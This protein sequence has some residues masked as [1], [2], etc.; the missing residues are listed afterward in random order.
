MKKAA[1]VLATS[2]AFFFG[3]MNA[4]AGRKYVTIP[5][6]KSVAT[7]AGTAVKDTGRVHIPGEP[8]TEYIPRTGTGTPGTPVK[9]LPTLDYSIPRTIN[10]AKNILKGNLGQILLQGTIAAAVAGVG[11]VMSDDNTKIQRKGNTVDGI[12]TSGPNNTVTWETTYICGYM[13]ASSILGKITPITYKN[14]LYAVWVGPSNAIPS[15]YTLNGNNCTQAGFPPGTVS[16]SR[17]IAFTDIKDGKFD[18]S[19][20]DW[21]GLDT[22][23]NAQGADWIK[24]LIRESCGGTYG[25]LNPDACYQGL[26]DSSKLSGP[27]TVSGGSTQ[28]LTSGPTG[29]TQNTKTTTYTITYGDTYFDWTT[30]INNH[31]VNPDG[32]T[33]DTTETED[34]KQEDPQAPAL[35]DPYAPVVDKYK[36]IADEVSN[37][38][39]VPATVNYSPWYSFGGNCT[40]LSFNLPIYGLYTTNIC[41]YIYNLV[42]P[43]IAFL[44][45]LWTWHRCREMWSEALRIGRPI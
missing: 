34:D 7:G 12:E 30:N 31:Q 41:P 44:L 3:A 14:I 15:G 43:V 25:G 6:A 17:A 29:I 27:A 2:V 26:V 21:S 13:S 40:E 11:W 22:Y 18:L 20:S 33:Q 8:G 39:Q 28:T 16:R 36:K 9:V 35:G 10:Q 4:E 24:S 38:P 1:L 45:A 42:Q 19:E 5:S 37:P 32:T 23:I